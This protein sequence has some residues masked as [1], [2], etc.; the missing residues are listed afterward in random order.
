[1]SQENGAA[2]AGWPT[3]PRR[4][5]V[6]VTILVAT[7]IAILVA[8]GCSSKKSPPKP[9]STQT[10]G[11][12]AEV[13]S[14]LT[15]IP[16]HGNILGNP[17]AALTLEYFGDLQCPFCRKFTLT[18]LSS[19][20]R[21]WVRAGKLKIVYRSEES[22]TR[23]PEVF[24]IQQVAALAAGKQNRMWDFLELFYRNQG[25]EGTG[26]V[27]EGFLQG[28]A[29]QVAGLDLI[30]WT[31]A[32]SDVGLASTISRDAQ[33]ANDAGLTGTPAFLLGRSGGPLRH[34][35]QATDTE[36]GPYDAAIE[37]LLRG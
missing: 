31:A 13:I 8:T 30:A 10:R 5:G 19:I 26:Y 14:L 21:M 22:A 24:K 2:K 36:A 15:G 34:F 28:L 18:A 3:R 9:R 20:I 4:P 17:S 1:M 37:R 32:R 35:R 11:T 7:V 16:Q 29:Q 23:D 33:A 25:R 27:T 6:V 12:D